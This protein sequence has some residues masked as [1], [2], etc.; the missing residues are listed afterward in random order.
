ML[1]KEQ[2]HA[3]W[4]DGFLVVDDA[5][6]PE[7]LQGMR[8]DFASW[9]EESRTH[10]ES[11]GETVDGRPRFDLDPSH[12]PDHPALRRVNAPVDVSEPFW[13]AASASVMTDAVA[14]L[15]GPN[16]VFHHAK[17]NSKASESVTPVMFHQDFPFEPHSND[18]LITALLALEDV[19]EANGALQVLPGS[20]KGP[21]FSLRDGS[22]KFTGAV[23][24]KTEAVCQRGSVLVRQKAGSVC[25]MHTRVLHGSRANTSNRPR[26]LFI[27]CFTSEDAVPLSP[28]PM[29]SK[30]MGALVRGERTGRV[31]CIDVDMELPDIPKGASFFDQQAD[32]AA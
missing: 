28:N 4:R 32:I 16:L 6:A 30:Y 9:T 24:A 11:Y 29:P 26:T 1:S 15:I 20:H 2:S 23:D 8:R 22:G 27:C 31:R 14:E 10:A 3:F 19:D 21:I 13:S 17:I 5:V 18:D 25:L 12:T 7:Q